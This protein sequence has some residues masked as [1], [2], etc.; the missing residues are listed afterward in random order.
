MTFNCCCFICLFYLDKLL[1]H[2]RKLAVPNFL[3]DL[4]EVTADLCCCFCSKFW[5]IFAKEFSVGNGES[6]F[7]HSGRLKIPWESWWWVTISERRTLMTITSISSLSP[8]GGQRW[9]QMG[10]VANWTERCNSREFISSL[11]SRSSLC[12]E[13]QQVR[14][15]LT[16][17]NPTHNTRNMIELRQNFNACGIHA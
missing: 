10:V 16:D 8:V 12:P 6:C 7:K 17:D 15:T 14:I 11:S 2:N 1:P 3:H 13:G 5:T 9:Y 4:K